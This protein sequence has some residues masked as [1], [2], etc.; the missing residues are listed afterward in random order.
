MNSENFIPR[1]SAPGFGFAAFNSAPHRSQKP[2]ILR[3]Q[4]ERTSLQ[5]KKPWCPLCSREMPLTRWFRGNNRSKTTTFSLAALRLEYPV[6][7]Q[8]IRRRH[9]TNTPTP[10]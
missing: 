5:V 7:I 3:S 2:N 8:Q 1:L 10:D 6:V 9:Q 4:K